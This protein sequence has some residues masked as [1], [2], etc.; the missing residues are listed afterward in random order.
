MAAIN[1]TRQT[2]VGDLRYVT[3]TF[4]FDSSYPTGG[5]AFDYA[6]LGL[7]NIDLIV[8]SP[9]LGLSFEYDYTA[10]KVKA[11][12][13]GMAIGAAG[14][15]S[16]DDFPLSGVG[17]TTVSVSLTSTA[18]TPIRLGGQQEIASTADLSTVTGVPFVAF[19]K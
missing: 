8:F 7:S 6:T 4:D 3:G 19:G 16:L 9:K 2:I 17:A 1:I 18:T 11:L 14:S 13:P 5:E 12:C 10:K 15:A